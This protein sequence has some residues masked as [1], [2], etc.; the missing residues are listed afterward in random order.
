MEDLN[1]MYGSSVLVL[2]SFVH[3]RKQNEMECRLML[4]ITCLML[5]VS[6]FVILSSIFPLFCA[7]LDYDYE[8]MFFAG[9]FST[10]EAC[11]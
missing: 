7:W 3:L 10:I 4:K 2:A 9:F 11:L 6:V 8:A 1:R 5:H